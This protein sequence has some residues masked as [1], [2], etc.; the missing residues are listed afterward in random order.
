MEASNV[1]RDEVATERTATCPGKLES[2]PGQEGCWFL[3]KI[4]QFVFSGVMIGSVY[5]L[6]AVAFCIVYKATEV[7]NFAQGEF[8]ML[9][10][11]IAASVFKTFGLSIPVSFAAAVGIA[12]GLGVFSERVTFGLS[13]HRAVLNLIIV[14]LGLGIAVKGAVMMIWGK[15]PKILPAFSGET[16]I[17]IFGAFLIPQA[18][19]IV[20]I[21]LVVM[22]CMRFFL[23]KTLTGTAMRAAAADRMAAS[24]VGISARHASNISFGIASA[25]GA[26]AGVIITPV[27]LTSYDHGTILGIKGFCAAVIGGLGNVYGG[28]LGGLILGLVEAFAAGWG[29]SGYRDV[30]AFLCLIFILL[31]RPK[32]LLGEFT[33][34]R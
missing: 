14:T 13:R 4:L 18:L 29:S 3:E 32:G 31:I 10:G 12:F 11:M 17:V 21:S 20:G 33:G 30:V 27:T 2:L 22:L 28:F 15:F 24:L 34:G 7:I 5:G 16:P 23:E 9:G 6:I 19:W 26:L 25:I 1:G 8:V